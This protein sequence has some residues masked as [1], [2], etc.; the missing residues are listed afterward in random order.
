MDVNGIFKFGKAAK[1][2]KMLRYG[3]LG[4]IGFNDMGLYTTGFN[5]TKLRDIIGTEV[6][7]MDML[8][9]E[10]EMEALD[11]DEVKKEIERVTKNWEYPTGKPKD[12]VIERVIR[13]YMATV[14]I[15]EE[16]NFHAFSYKCVDGID[17]EMNAAYAVLS[18][19][20]ASDGYPDIDENDIG[21]LIA[22]LILKW[23][24]EME[25]FDESLIMYNLS[26]LLQYLVI[27]RMNC[28]TSA[29]F[30]A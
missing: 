22:E 3:R 27:T 28:L 20:V 25:M 26:T 30:R 19:L 4:M 10:R 5:V 24:T 23:I 29:T 9:L 12:E 7:V 1:V 11:P 21:N 18:A 8:Q 13:M 2:M 14:K 16:K 15:C 17:L 6:E